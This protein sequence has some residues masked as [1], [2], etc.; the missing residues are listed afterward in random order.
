[1]S[2]TKED[3]QAIQ[4]II[5][6]TIAQDV[7]NIVRSILQ[8]EAPRIVRETVQP[9]LNDLEDRTMKRFDR[10]AQR[11]DDLDDSLS[12]QMEAGLQQIRDQLGDHETRLHT[13]ERKLKIRTA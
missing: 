9:M 7:P 2:L 4:C 8:H 10:L 11:I 12:L 13:V 3:L 1:M 6:G 5:S